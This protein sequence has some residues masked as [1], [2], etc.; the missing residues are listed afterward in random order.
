MTAF[1]KTEIEARIRL[2]AE[3]HDFQTALVKALSKV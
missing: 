1:G 2:T 3:L